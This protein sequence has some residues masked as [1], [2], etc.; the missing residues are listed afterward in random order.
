MK[1]GFQL[2]EKQ[3]FKFYTD[4]MTSKYSVNKYLVKIEWLVWMVL[5]YLMYFICYSITII[6]NFLCILY[7]TKN[8]LKL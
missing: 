1:A 2:R 6:P 7:D 8:I 5:C 3:P 4:V